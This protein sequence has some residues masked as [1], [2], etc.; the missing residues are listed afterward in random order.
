MPLQ[1]RTVVRR[2][3]WS[4]QHTG[5]FF[6]EETQ[7][8]TQVAFH[9]GDGHGEQL[10]NFF[11]RSVLLVAQCDDGALR[12]RKRSHQ[13]PELAAEQRIAGQG[14]DGRLGVLIIE[15]DFRTAFALAEPVDGAVNGDAAEPVCDVVRRIEVRELRVQFEEDILRGLFGK[16]AVVEDAQGDAE[17]HGLVLE[18]QAA[19]TGIGSALRNPHVCLLWTNT[20]GAGKEEAE[21]LGEKFVVL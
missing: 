10:R 19:E 17:D 13:L 15:T 2:L 6:A 1:G 4:S 5:E 14:F 11:R 9:S 16:E 20:A 7:R 3:V 21:S 12:G 18:H 8:A